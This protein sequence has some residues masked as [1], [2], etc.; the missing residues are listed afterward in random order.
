[1]DWGTLVVLD[2]KQ[3]MSMAMLVEAVVVLAV[4]VIMV[5]VLLVVMVV[6]EFNYLLHLEILSQL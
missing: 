3:V 1:M 5:Q 6:L 4:L 2:G